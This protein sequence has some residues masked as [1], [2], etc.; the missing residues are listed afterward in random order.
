MKWTVIGSVLRAL[1]IAIKSSFAYSAKPED[2][3]GWTAVQS[4]EYCPE[5][6]ECLVF[7]RG[8]A[9][10]CVNAAM[11]VTAAKRQ[12]RKPAQS[13]PMQL[14]TNRHH[15]LMPHCSSHSH[16]ISQFTRSPQHDKHAVVKRM[17]GVSFI[18]QLKVRRSSS[19]RQIR[20][21]PSTARGAA[22][23]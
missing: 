18:F 9:V 16:P 1:F 3:M 21:S 15:A 12:A 8:K 13:V 19:F 4:A 20:R 22:V 7:L 17:S 2:A 14:A 11:T 10:R 6:A 5:E 23:R